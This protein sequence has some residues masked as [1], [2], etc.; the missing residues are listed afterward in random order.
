LVGGGTAPPLDEGEAKAKLSLERDLQ[1]ALRRSITQLE[2]GLR[3]DDGGV[4][5]SV[6]SGRI[7]ILARDTQGLSVVIELKAV[8]AQRDA[9]AQVLA[10]MGDIQ[11]TET[12]TVRGI[13]V[14]PDFDAKAVSAARMV[15]SLSLFSFH[16]LFRFEKR[17]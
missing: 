11:I 7:D 13:L 2:P 8:T 10:Y 16:F 9:V 4:E 3:I 17:G 15:P 12:N 6:P 14:A 1:S 5:R